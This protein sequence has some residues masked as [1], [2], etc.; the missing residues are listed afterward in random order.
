VRP[1]GTASVPHDQ[2]QSLVTVLDGVRLGSAQTRPELVRVTGLGRGLVAQRVNELLSWGILVEN[3]LGVS[4]GGRAP[5]TL[6]FNADAGRLLVANLGVTSITAGIANLAGTIIARHHEPHDIAVGPEATLRRLEEVFDGLLAA[7]PQDAPPLWGIGCGLPGPVE[8]ATGR[9]I[10]PPVMPGWD[11]YPV[12]NRLAERYQAP[13][14]VDNDVNLMAIGELRAGQAQGARNVVFVKIGGEVGAGIICAG[15]LHRG[16]QGA[17]GDVG[18]VAV[19]DDKSILC[20][21]GNTGCL[22]ALAGGHALGL[23][24][25]RAALD[26]SSPW[27]A[28][29]LAEGTALTSAHVTE[30]ASHGDPACVELVVSAGYLVGGV[31]ATVVNFYN[32]S[33][34]VIGGSVAEAGDRLLATIRQIIYSRSLPLATRELRIVRCLLGPDVGTIGAAFMVIDE[35]FAPATLAQWIAVGTP[36]CRPELGRSAHAA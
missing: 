13:T 1:G 36:A 15:R 9:P 31:L 26:G 34:L 2:L 10:A 30:G 19:V 7:S 5:R 20:R 27:L 12:S 35:L 32:P 23:Q 29:R 3:G 21:C 18:H 16:E 4:A 22:E 33:L 8:F 28:A 6:R 14:W 25:R 24:A 11:H 17:A